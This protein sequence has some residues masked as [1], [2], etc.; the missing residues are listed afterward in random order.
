LSQ[1]CLLPGGTGTLATIDG[2]IGEQALMDGE[3]GQTKTQKAMPQAE[4]A[5]WKALWVGEKMEWEEKHWTLVGAGIFE[6]EAGNVPL[7]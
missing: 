2:S 4:L 1:G 5:A 7:T 3:K 6:G